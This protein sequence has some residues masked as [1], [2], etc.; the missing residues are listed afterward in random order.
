MRP[1]LR[2]LAIR[3]RLPYSR[4]GDFL[5]K[6]RVR[7][8]LLE[9]GVVLAGGADAVGEDGARGV[10]VVAD[11]GCLLYRMAVLR[12]GGGGRGEDTWC[13]FW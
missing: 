5:G 9:D 8:Q 7:L 3:F 12:W 13:H 4:P 11:F 10:V 2:I 1:T 6:G